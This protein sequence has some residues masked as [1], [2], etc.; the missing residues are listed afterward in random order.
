MASSNVRDRAYCESA[1]KNYEVQLERVVCLV[2]PSPV[3]GSEHHVVFHSCFRSWRLHQ[4]PWMGDGNTGRIHALWARSGDR[5]YKTVRTF[6]PDVASFR[7][8]LAQASAASIVKRIGVSR[9]L[10]SK[11]F[12][13]SADFV[14][15]SLTLV[16]AVGTSRRLPPPRAAGT[17]GYQP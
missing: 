8:A 13:K 16:V 2:D 4:A 11:R 6:R 12:A 15:D 3:A 10:A 5:S 7:S 17:N 14:D 9:W 1:Q